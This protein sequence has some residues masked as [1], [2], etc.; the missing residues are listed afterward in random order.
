[1]G[2]HKQIQENPVFSEANEIYLHDV[3]IKANS[4]AP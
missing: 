2:H 3:D 1:M 4:R